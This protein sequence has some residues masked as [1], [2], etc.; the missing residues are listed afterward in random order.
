[1]KLQ[2]QIIDHLERFVTDG[3]AA[4]GAALL[5]GQERGYIV[6][7]DQPDGTGVSLTFQ[8]SDRYSINLRRLEVKGP[9]TGKKLTLADCATHIATRLSYLEEPL[10]LVE[11]DGTQDVAL[12]RS[13]PPQQNGDSITYWEAALHASPRPHVSLTR[14]R[15]TPQQQKRSVLHQPLTFNTAGRIATDLAE[16]LSNPAL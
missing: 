5:K 13:N 15:W 16:S 6:G 12:L 11:L 3:P 4:V 10:A 14:Y 7:V 8:D 1:M 9:D 2:Q